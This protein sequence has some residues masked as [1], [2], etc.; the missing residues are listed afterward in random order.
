M[1]TTCSNL[2]LSPTSSHL[3][4]SLISP[5]LSR[6]LSSS[7]KKNFQ[8]YTSGYQNSWG[9]VSC[10]S[11]DDGLYHW[12]TSKR[13]SAC[14][15]CVGVHVYIAGLNKY[16]RMLWVLKP[17][18]HRQRARERETRP[19]P[20]ETRGWKGKAPRADLEPGTHTQTHTHTHT[21]M[22]TTFIVSYHVYRKRSLCT[23][24]YHYIS[25]CQKYCYLSFHHD[26]LRQVP[27]TTLQHGPLN[28]T[29][30]T[31][32][33]LITF[34][35]LPRSSRLSF[36]HHT[37]FPICHVYHVLVFTISPRELTFNYSTLPHLLLWHAYTMV[38]KCMYN[39]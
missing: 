10:S 26:P 31:V 24:M 36:Y 28:K 6:S 11:Y 5:H 20:K 14:M 18:S 37:T 1:T 22:V 21:Y 35:I 15:L 33:R 34:I 27:F 9:M 38:C 29:V 16:S 19:G 17:A 2:S 32:Y 39:T 7:S 23:T 4:T 12:R 25:C 3:N 30:I 8:R 13:T